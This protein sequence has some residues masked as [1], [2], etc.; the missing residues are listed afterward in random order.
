MKTPSR[1]SKILIAVAS[2]F[3]GFS[4]GLVSAAGFSLIERG[5]QPGRARSSARAHGWASAVVMNS[6]HPCR[7]SNVLSR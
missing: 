3:G 6:K 7:S 1:Q 5:V 4:T 2:I